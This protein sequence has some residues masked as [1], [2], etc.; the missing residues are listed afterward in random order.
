LA[1]Y[2]Q[3]V[4][5][6]RRQRVY[7]G[8]RRVPE[9]LVISPADDIPPRIRRRLL[10]AFVARA[11]D[12][13]I[14]DSARMGLVVV[15]DAAGEIFSWLWLSDPDQAVLRMS[16]LM[17]EIHVHNRDANPC[18]SFHDVLVAFEPAMPHDFPASEYSKF[19]T[20]CRARV[21]NY[22]RDVERDA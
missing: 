19:V 9:A 3:L 14:Q 4:A 12:H 17:A 1:R 6:D 18:I 10:S 15:D 8:A 5:S 13:I 16:E 11:A 20:E 2:L 22:F 7:V 21:P